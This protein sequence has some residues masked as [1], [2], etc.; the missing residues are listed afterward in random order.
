VT[1]LVDP[2][3]KVLTEIR[4]DVGVAGWAEDRVRPGEPVEGDALGPGKYKRFIVVSVLG[5]ARQRRLPVQEVRALVKCYGLTAQDAAAGAMLVSAAV[6]ARGPRIRGTVGIFNT[7]DEGGEGYQ[8]DPDTKQPYETVI[9][10][11][12][13][14][15]P[16]IA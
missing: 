5:R 13:A 6:H 2:V 8:K 9:V 11:I 16:P 7:W 10:S 3:G 15:T 1:V 14:A 12:D 4:D